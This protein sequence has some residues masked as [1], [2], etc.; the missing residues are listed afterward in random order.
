MAV[1]TFLSRILGL[2]REQVMAFMFGA[3]GFTDAYNI[4]F[5]I[6]NLLRDL[7]AEGAFSAAFVPSFIELNQKSH[8]EAKKLLW[9][10][11]II[12]ILATGAISVL[13]F[14]FAPEIISLFAPTFV[15]NPDKFWIT[16]TLTRIM[17]PFLIFVS[18]AAL[19]MGALNSLKVFFIPS[20]A[21]AFFNVTMILAM[22]GLPTILS[23]RDIPIIYSLGIGVLIG[24]FVQFCVQLPLIYKKGFISRPKFNGFHKETKRVITKL[25]PAL[26]GFAATQVNLIITT[27]LASGTMIGAVSWLN[28]AFRLFQLPVGILS[29]SLGNSNLVHFSNAW[30]E[31][32]FDSAKKI[33]LSSYFSSWIIMLPALL[34]V[35]L[36]SEEIVQV[37]FQRGAFDLLAT[38]MT[39]KALVWYAIGLPFY[40]IYKLLVPCFYTLDKQKIPVNTSMFAIG[41]NILFC[42]ALTPI[43]GFEVLAFGTSLSMIINSSILMFFISKHTQIKFNHFFN[44][45]FFKLTSF[46]L[47]LFVGAFFFKRSFYPQNLGLFLNCVSLFVGFALVSFVYVT[48]IYIL[49]E[50]S[51]VLSVLRKFKR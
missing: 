45:R 34:V 49:G 1:A 5:R 38:A 29:V 43:Y 19:M 44:L 16:V 2:V 6:P 31:K 13:T 50:R 9:S 7:F 28:Y 23:S 12:L 25:G 10:L 32:D 8:K 51:V 36:F 37:V 48:G 26:L 20:L 30:K 11:F 39:S 3:S 40:G 4:A 17:S 35:V 15:N 21:P 18:L 42:L 46:S 33:L 41:I 24:G 14:I 47:F 22:L 27:I